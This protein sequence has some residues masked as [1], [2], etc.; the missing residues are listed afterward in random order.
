MYLNDNWIKQG[1]IDRLV[2]LV[3]KAE[4]L[5]RLNISDSTMGTEGVLLLVKALQQNPL[6]GK[7]L[8]Y[9]SCNYNEVESAKV[10]KRILDMLVAFEALELVEF[11]GNTI[12]RKAA[13]EYVA[14][15]EEKGCKLVMFDEEEEED[16]EAE[17]EEDEKEAEEGAEEEE[18][19]K[20]LEKLKL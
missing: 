20:K 13:L 16:E 9:F 15:F 5:E 18:L 1:A 19:L 17:E 14:R 10:S 12:S 7:S 6:L 2:E 8:K 11:K 3:I 4:R